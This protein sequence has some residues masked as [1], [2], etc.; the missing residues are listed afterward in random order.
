ME[1]EIHRKQGKKGISFRRSL[2]VMW[3]KD[4]GRTGAGRNVR[5]SVGACVCFDG[6]GL[7]L[8]LLKCCCH[9]TVEVT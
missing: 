1:S 3:G 2:A 7:S 9:R 8:C 5:V 4:V 6:E